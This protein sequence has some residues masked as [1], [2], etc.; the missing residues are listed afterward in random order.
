MILGFA[1]LELGAKCE[2]VFVQTFDDASYETA[3]DQVQ[4]IKSLSGKG[5]STIK[6]LDASASRPAGCVAF[7][8]SS[9]AAVFLAVKGRVDM[10]AEIAKATTKLAKAK[11][12]AEKTAKVLADPGYREKVAAATQEIDRKRLADYESEVK[13]LEATI[14]QF[15]GLKLEK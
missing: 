13:H 7:P 2:T 12:N 1:T 4:A 6:I 14:S 8:V 15:E 5:I 10:D 9:S 3:K 11:T